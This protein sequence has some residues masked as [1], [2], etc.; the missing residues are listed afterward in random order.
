MDVGKAGDVV[1]VVG[2]VVDDGVV[3]DVDVDGV[4]VVDVGGVGDVGGGVGD[5]DGGGV[6]LPLLLL[7]GLVSVLATVLLIWV[8]S[9]L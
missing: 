2:D 9:A 5:G 7:M 4:V 6:V 1:G 3:V 8:T